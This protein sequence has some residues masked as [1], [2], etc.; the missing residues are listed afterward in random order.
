MVL[1]EELGT[2]A[3]TPYFKEIVQ[4]FGLNLYEILAMNMV[5]SVL[6]PNAFNERSFVNT[7]FFFWA[8]VNVTLPISA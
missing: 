6:C 7:F 2:L 5:L 4:I 8:N 3:P 1:L